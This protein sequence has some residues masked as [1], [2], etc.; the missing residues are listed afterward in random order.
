MNK[1]KQDLPIKTIKSLSPRPETKI[2][3]LRSPR[4]PNINPTQKL[5]QKYFSPKCESPMGLLELKTYKRDGSEFLSPKEERKTI[6]TRFTLDDI[7]PL[8]ISGSQSILEESTYDQ[9]LTSLKSEVDTLKTKLNTS[10]IQFQTKKLTYYQKLL[11]SIE[12]SLNLDSSLET[13]YSCPQSTEETIITEKEQESAQFIIESI[14]NLQ[15]ELSKAQEQLKRKEKLSFKEKKDDTVP[16]QSEIQSLKNYIQEL[17]RK[18]DKLKA[19]KMKAKQQIQQNEKDFQD[20]INNKEVEISDIKLE[21]KEKVLEIDQLKEILNRSENQKKRLA[22]SLKEMEIELNRV[23]N[24]Y[25]KVDIQHEALKRKQQFM[26]EQLSVYE[27]KAKKYEMTAEQLE[28]QNLSLCS[29]ELKH[30]EDAD[31]IKRLKKNADSL[32]YTFE[33]HRQ[34][35]H[36][37][38]QKYQNLIQEL[39]TQVENERVHTEI[40]VHENIKLKK[41]ISFKDLDESLSGFTR[42]EVNRYVNRVQQAELEV[43]NSAIEVEKMKKTIEYYKELVRNKN[44]IIN[45]LETETVNQIS[46]V[47]LEVKE[48]R[49]EEE[50][51]EL[52]DA[53]VMLKANLMCQNCLLEKSYYMVSPCGNFIC[54]ECKPEHKNCPVCGVKY[55]VCTPCGLLGNLDDL[56]E[57]LKKVLL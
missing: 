15:T 26:V 6:S 35:W 25:M 34:K 29:L 24:E 30:S 1:L 47:S 57:K 45:R 49:M 19:G 56:C 28:N 5:S 3:Y 17:N 16:L 55:E 10:T 33:L 42:D 7:A 31:I 32:E 48:S 13:L 38:E 11:I 18:I 2:S 14:K 20:I 37:K 40:Q 4:L 41:A 27:E 54:K 39:L 52:K 9:N 22:D 51:V 21:V 46:P 44:E 23:R 50:N 36:N 8:K 43:T 12:K 53:L